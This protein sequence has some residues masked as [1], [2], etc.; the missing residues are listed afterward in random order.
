MCFI[1]MSINLIC[2]LS[3]PPTTIL[4]VPIFDFANDHVELAGMAMDGYYPCCGKNIC[5]GCVHSFNTSGNNGKC[6][7]GNSDR[8]NK[9]VEEDV[10]VS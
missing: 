9:I 5:N 1:P 10:E 6:P 2:C 7:F 3:L 4:S 8:V